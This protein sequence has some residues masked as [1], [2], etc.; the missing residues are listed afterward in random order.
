MKEGWVFDLGTKAYAETLELQ[1]QLVEKK[2]K[3]NLP[4]ILLLVEHNPVIT[5]GRSSHLENILLDKRQLEKL[6]IQLHYIERGGD[7]TY[8]GPG[9]LVAY[10]IFDLNYYKQDTHLFLRL[11]EEVI[12]KT[13]ESYHLKA[14]RVKGLTGVW[15]QGKK[16][17]SIGVAAKKWITFHGLAIN[18]NTDLKNFSYIHPC[19]MLDKEVTS[20]AELL[21]KKIEPQKVKDKIVNHFGEV[22]DLNLIK[23]SRLPLK[24]EVLNINSKG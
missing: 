17:A 16:V 3:E 10:P 12:I 7:V 23:N 8:H 13:V 11:L 6:N 4:E 18:V 22:F 15:V 20:L 1:H 9:Q 14:E 2:H 21:R 19:G 24:Q 5:L